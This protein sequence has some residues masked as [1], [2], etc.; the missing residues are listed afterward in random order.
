MENNRLLLIV[1]PQIDFI[2]GSLPV[3][4]AAEAMDRL[5]EYVAQH[6]DDYAVKMVTSDW[7]PY[8]HCSFSRKGGEWPAHCVQHS[9]GAAVYQPLLEALNTSR[10]GFTMLYKGNRIDKDEY[11][12][13]QNA[14]SAS[15]LVRLIAALQIEQV[16][17]CGLAGNI[18]VL[19]TARDMLTLLGPTMVRVLSEFSPS[20]DDGS[21][22]EAFIRDNH[23]IGA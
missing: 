19:N 13:M 16:D 14:D 20:L 3:P 8:N 4:K 22:L 10:G 17:I 11:S 1:D 12:I 18:C 6:G 15:V 5:A 7:H 9:V 2:S 21:E 23:L